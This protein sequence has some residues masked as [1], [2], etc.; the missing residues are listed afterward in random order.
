AAKRSVRRITDYFNRL[1]ADGT[2][3]AA[4]TD[5][6][7]GATPLFDPADDGDDLLAGVL[8]LPPDSPLITYPAASSSRHK[9]RAQTSD[10]RSNPKMA[11]TAAASAPP[12]ADKPAAPTTAKEALPFED[13]DEDMDLLLNAS[14]HFLNCT[15][16]VEETDTRQ[17]IADATPKPA[18]TR[19]SA[20]RANN[21]NINTMPTLFSISRACS[22]ELSAIL[23]TPPAASAKRANRPTHSLDSLLND[24]M[25]R[26]KQL[27]DARA[28]DKMLLQER[29]SVEGTIVAGQDVEEVDAMNEDMNENSNP[30]SVLQKV[31]TDLLDQTSLPYPSTN[32]RTLR[33]NTTAVV[34][35]PR[36][37]KG[38]K[39]DV[40]TS[41]R[42]SSTLGGEE[43]E[44]DEDE[45]SLSATKVDAASVAA[46]ESK[47]RIRSLVLDGAKGPGIVERVVMVDAARVCLPETSFSYMGAEGDEVTDMVVAALAD[48][49]TRESFL[50]AGTISNSI[51]SAGWN[52][53]DGLASWLFQTACFSKSTELAVAAA[54]NLKI[55]FEFES[56]SWIISVDKFHDALKAYGFMDELFNRE[57]E[58]DITAFVQSVP[59]TK[60]L[61]SDSAEPVAGFPTLN[62]VLCVELY[63]LCLIKR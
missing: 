45:D 49:D 39:T 33:G 50:M 58:P 16:K 60:E 37:R 42:L 5:D 59:R 62:F 63:T 9:R 2:T 52:L 1:A 28:I 47:E 43:D 53:P 7:G 29:R 21:D 19:T 55:S 11:K 26:E 41:L 20:S 61:V 46:L 27:A 14:Y 18:T 34:K 8:S 40:G 4:R 10:A 35:K 44:E 38:S 3:D 22:A 23:G 17:S 31:V 30:D 25:K 56:S 15:K 13:D 51:K 24:K 57:D 54:R 6:D 36:R 48:A 12:L 32:V